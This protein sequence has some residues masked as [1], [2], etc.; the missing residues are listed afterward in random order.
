[1]VLDLSLHIL[2]I[3]ENSI[4]AGARQVHIDVEEDLEGD[5]LV[6]E[7]GDD[8]LGMDDHM[9]RKAA[10]PFVTTRRERRVG[11]GLPLLSEAA[12]R[13]GG[14]VSV[15]SRPDGGTQI[16]ASFGHSHIDRQPLGDIGKTL[17]TLVTGH[18]GVE[19]FYQHRRAG[20]TYVFNSP[21]VKVRLA[22]RPITSPEGI[23]L[24]RTL[25]KERLPAGSSG[26]TTPA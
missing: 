3:A 24:L 23:G 11:F 25:L 12:R 1:V 21:E 26:H 10:D 9:V 13:G 14:E 4:T 17:L 22:G 16:K 8:G 19:F 6:I 5:R 15:R 18:P 2:D 7:I 20:R